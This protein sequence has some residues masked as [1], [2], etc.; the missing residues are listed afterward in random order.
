MGIGYTYYLKEGQL[1][2]KANCR[3]FEG[4]KGYFEGI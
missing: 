4:V 3:C 2:I 1:N